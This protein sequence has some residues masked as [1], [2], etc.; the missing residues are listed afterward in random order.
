MLFRSRLD[1]DLTEIASADPRTPEEQV[2]ARELIDDIRAGLE[3][4]GRDDLLDSLDR[5]GASLIFA[6]PPLEPDV[7]VDVSTLILL[8]QPVSVFSSAPG[9]PIAAFD[10]TE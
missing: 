3:R 4:T 6:V 7:A 8:G 2:R 10:G 5:P 9:V 1:P